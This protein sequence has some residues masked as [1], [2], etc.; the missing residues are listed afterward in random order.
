MKAK[1]VIIELVE[2]YKT[3]GYTFSTDTIKNELTTRKIKATEKYINKTIR[4]LGFKY[5]RKT[6]N[7]RMAKVEE[8]PETIKVYMPQ[9][10]TYV[11][12][13]KT[14]VI[15]NQKIHILGCFYDK[16]KAEEHLELQKEF[17]LRLI[18][19]NQREHPEHQINIAL[20]LYSFD[21]HS[22]KDGLV[23]PTEYIINKE[24]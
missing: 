15:I 19:T 21:A 6:S 17:F 1:D 16:Q 7:W 23:F 12:D 18:E 22:T 20:N 3:K 8:L 13:S 14:K 2:K 5:D 24:K 9:I 10:I 4:S 11:S